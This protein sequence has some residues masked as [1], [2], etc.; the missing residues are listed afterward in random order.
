[1]EIKIKLDMFEGP[2]DLLLHLIETAEVD[3]YQVSIAKI[4]DQYMQ[5]LNEAE[6]MELEVASE[7]L[8]MAA[9]L[10][11]IKS[12]MLLPRHEL[13]EEDLTTEHEGW[14]EDPRAELVERLLEYKKYKRLGE[15]LRMREEE[16]SKVYSRPAMDLTPYTPEENPVEGLSP[17]DL[18][19][20]FVETL[21]N[22]APQEQ[23]TRL[24][25]EEISVSDR[26][27]EIYSLLTRKGQLFFSRLIDWN[28]VTREWIITTFLALL[29]LMKL[30]KIVCY[31]EGLFGEIRV[32]VLP[33]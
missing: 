19:Q 22:R 3:I 5:V 4:T 18:L 30:K 16:R 11:A 23:V 31:Q 25:R 1:M 6:Q 33:G 20:V 32:E 2:L 14:F 29:E 24:V 12:K 26:M 8:V 9:T 7:F 17:D 13:L 28:T 15:V 10:L 27:E 21:K